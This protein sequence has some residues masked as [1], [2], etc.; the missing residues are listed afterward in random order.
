MPRRR[1][2]DLAQPPLTSREV[3]RLVDRTLTEKQWQKQ[4]ENALTRFGWWWMHIP[5]NVI[6]CE[7]C[8]HRNYRGIKRGFPD[9]FTI[10]PPFIRWIELKTE[11][12][13]LDSDQKRIHEMLRACGQVVLNARPR[14]REQL[15]RAIANPE[16]P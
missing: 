14:D 4:V 6:I 15:F 12:G 7:R 3:K 8:G 5:A 16:E 13:R 2:P 1:E 10:K 9:L 11:V